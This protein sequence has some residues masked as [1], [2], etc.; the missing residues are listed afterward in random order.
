[1][2]LEIEDILKASPYLRKGV[3]TGMPSRMRSDSSEDQRDLLFR[4]NN[5]QKIPFSKVTDSKDRG[6]RDNT[7]LPMDEEIL[8]ED[9]NHDGRKCPRCNRG[10]L[11]TIENP[12]TG[13]V[14][15]EFC[16]DCEYYTEKEDKQRPGMEIKY[17]TE[18]RAQEE[19]EKL[20]RALWARFGSESKPE[21][22]TI[23]MKEAKVN[24]AN[25]STEGLRAIYSDMK[26]YGEDTREVE[27]ELDRRLKNKST[28][29]GKKKYP[30]Q[31]KDDTI[32]VK[33]WSS[34]AFKPTRDMDNQRFFS[35]A[36]FDKMPFGEAGKVRDDKMRRSGGIEE[37]ERYNEKESA[38]VSKQRDPHQWYQY[39]TMDGKKKILEH[40]GVDV[41][42]LKQDWDE[43]EGLPEDVRNKIN[44]LFET[45]HKKEGRT[46]KEVQ[47]N[48]QYGDQEGM[49]GRVG[50]NVK[51]KKD[52]DAKEKRSPVPREA[53]KA[54]CNLCKEKHEEELECPLCQKSI[55]SDFENE[56]FTCPN[57]VYSLVRIPN[58]EDLEIVV[59]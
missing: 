20:K 33:G 19:A 7:S 3:A 35:Q 53:V 39:S 31:S 48:E 40:A 54:E 27:E 36:V 13:E 46:Y 2:T 44:Q 15:A 5:Q 58:Q 41:R 43:Y 10:P 49:L 6:W 30:K 42:N 37:T 17:P 14:E 50:F 9:V 24:W 11:G 4:L 59:G 16:P 47:Q 22:E 32:G 52:T 21:V 56:I 12:E 34:L 57:C 18:E 8:K 1:M 23:E 55:C 29:N 25:Y 28:I 38:E 26:N 51:P 45:E